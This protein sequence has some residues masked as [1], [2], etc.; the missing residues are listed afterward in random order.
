MKNQK[1][2]RLLKARIREF[3]SKGRITWG[4]E[5]ASCRA[6]DEMAR[7]IARRDAR[8]IETAVTKF[9]REFVSLTDSIGDE[10]N[11]V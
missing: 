4:Q 6:L 5:E 9:V 3:G 1:H 7:A 10:T 8:D 2:V 11:D